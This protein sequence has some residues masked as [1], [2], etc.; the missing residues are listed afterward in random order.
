MLQA[1]PGNVSKMADVNHPIYVYKNAETKLQTYNI[2]YNI[3]IYYS[4]CSVVVSLWV[5]LYFD[6]ARNS[7][8]S[9]HLDHFGSQL[10]SIKFRQGISCPTVGTSIF[11]SGGPSD[12]PENRSSQTR[13]SSCNPD[14]WRSPSRK[15]GVILADFTNGLIGKIGKMVLT[16]HLEIQ[17][18]LI[19]VDRCG[20][21][22]ILGFEL[23]KMWHFSATTKCTCKQNP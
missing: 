10:A 2:S 16:C 9:K 4:D 18:F 5:N 20:H 17:G 14:F 23:W 3:Y 15:H 8:S 22:G 6:V 7:L 13:K 21:H 1:Y 11:F 19:D 12:F